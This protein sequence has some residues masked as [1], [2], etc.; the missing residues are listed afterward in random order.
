MQQSTQCNT[1]TY[2]QTIQKRMKVILSLV[3]SIFLSFL[4]QAQTLQDLEFGTS[5]T[6]EVITWN[7]QDYPRQGQNTTEKV[8]EIIE[9]LDV[10]VIAL[11]EIDN[12]TAF[13]HLINNLEG[14][15]GYYTTYDYLNL[16]YLYKSDVVEVVDIFEI[17]RDDNQ[18]F[19]RAPYV[20]EMN[21]QGD[22]YVVINNHL[23][24]C[25][26][27]WLDQTDP[28]DE[29]T[30]RFSASYLLE[31]Y[32]DDNYPNDRVFVVG[33]FNDLLTDN[34]SNNVFQPFFSK[35]NDYRFADMEIAEG[36]SANWSYPDWPSHLDHILVTN[37]LFD[38]LE[39]GTAKVETLRIGDYM[40]GGSWEYMNKVSDHRPVGLR[41]NPT[42]VSVENPILT[43]WNFSI[44]PN[45]FHGQ[46]IL[47]FDAMDSHAQLTIYDLKGR[48]VENFQVV[49]RQFSIAW[50][51]KGLSKGMYY[52][53]LMVDNSV[54]VRKLVVQ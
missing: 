50:D 25:G 24:C 8:I 38:V 30:R 49:P 41:I 9:A 32:V 45:P 6:L 40:S 23:K 47:S 17:Y 4:L 5:T 39:H 1:I 35:P 36:S 37:E 33:D 20:L 43:D 14:W 52:A 19:P 54:V 46:T 12:L 7:I 21:Y 26:D 51:A 31:Q 42:L 27:G 22:F 44:S 18:T 16:A 29:E 15:E 28:W 3:F 13:Q 48:L 2:H 34:S 10:D 11:Q 53:R